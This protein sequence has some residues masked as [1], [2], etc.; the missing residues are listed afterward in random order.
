MEI[1]A[2]ATAGF[3]RPP[4]DVMVMQPHNGGLQAGHVAG[5]DG[6]KWISDFV[7]TDFW[8]GPVYRNQIPRPSYVVYRY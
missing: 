6:Q 1:S 3:A 8:A 2:R 7:Q 4:A 5:Y